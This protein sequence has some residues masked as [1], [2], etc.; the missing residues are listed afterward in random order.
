[1]N[2]H[3]D[4]SAHNDRRPNIDD[5]AFPLSLA[6]VITQR[7]IDTTD[8]LFPKHLGQLVFFQGRMQQQS[9]KL[10][11]LF[12][13]VQGIQCHCLKDGP[14][15]LAGDGVGHGLA[16]TDRVMYSSSFVAK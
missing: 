7:L 1:M 4:E 2:N 14:V 6:E 15:I 9:L 16:R 3:A 13:V 10:R 11:I 12:V 8:K 5:C